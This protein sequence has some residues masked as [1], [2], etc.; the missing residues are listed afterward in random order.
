MSTTQ[1]KSI[2]V[3][4]GSTQFASLSDSVLSEATLKGLLAIGVSRL[5]VQLG[6]A[7]VPPH[8][9]GVVGTEGGRGSVAGLE[10]IVLRYTSSQGEMDS[11]MRSV[12]AVV[13]HA[14]ESS[15]ALLAT[16]YRARASL[17]H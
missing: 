17:R 5:V 3:T 14:G 12:D 16:M 15:S 1:G 6:S 11:L 7:P 9:A 4:V 13:S 8:I 10:V 2:L